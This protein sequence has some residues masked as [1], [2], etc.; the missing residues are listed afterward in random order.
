MK[1]VKWLEQHHK[2]ELS[3]YFYG[4][5]Q[6]QWQRVWRKFF[7]DSHNRINCLCLLYWFALIWLQLSPTFTVFYLAFWR[8]PPVKRVPEL[9]LI[10]VALLNLYYQHLIYYAN[11]TTVSHIIKKLLLEGRYTDFIP[12]YRYTKNRHVLSYFKWFAQLYWS[13]VI[14]LRLF[15]GSYRILLQYVSA[16]ILFIFTD[17]FV[18]SLFLNV[19][20]FTWSHLPSSLELNK[21]LQLAIKSSFL[22][23]CIATMAYIIHH[24]VQVGLLLSHLAIVTLRILH[25]QIWQSKQLLARHSSVLR[26]QRFTRFNKQILLQILQ[27]NSCYGSALLAFLV[28]FTPINCY[29]LILVVTGRALPPVNYFYTF[30]AFLHFFVIVGIHVVSAN[31]NFYFLQSNLQFYSCMVQNAS[32]TPIRASLKLSLYFHAFHT[33]NRYGFSYKYFGRISKFSFVKVEFCLHM[34]FFLVTKQ[35]FLFANMFSQCRSTL[36]S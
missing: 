6:C 8:F 9:T 26:L 19:V 20:K 35:F 24:F 14:V 15:S 4:V 3:A 5:D 1:C 31:F 36:N 32:F 27:A 18:G 22:L 28:V 34:L 30:N 2:N 13:L 21:L 17:I 7:F 12:P 25:V 33:Q 11:D 10:S 29:L 23:M 16:N